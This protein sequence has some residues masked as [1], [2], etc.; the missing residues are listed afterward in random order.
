LTQTANLQLPA[1]DC[2]K[3]LEPVKPV[4]T[5]WDSY[6]AAFGR[7][8]QLQAA[9]DLYAEHHINRINLSNRRAT[10]SGSKL[11]D[12][13]AWMRSTGLTAANWTVITEYQDCLKP[14][15][16][17]TERLEGRGKAGRYGAIY[18]IILVFEYV[19]NSLEVCTQLYN[20]VN[21][22]ELDTPEDH[23]IIN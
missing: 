20:H 4:V 11:A 8:T 23:L 21:F 18:E 5:R 13:P 1:E 3:V 10:Q 9:Y 19:L 6:Y 2:H 14:L 12:A 7:A 22:N 16:L 17:A 15:K